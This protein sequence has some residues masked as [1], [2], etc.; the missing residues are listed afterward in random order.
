MEQ[1]FYLCFSTYADSTKPAADSSLNKQLSNE[2][3]DGWIP[4]ISLL[5]TLWFGIM[6][7]RYSVCKKTGSSRGYTLIRLH[8]GRAW[9]LIQVV[10]LPKS[11]A[12]REIA[13][14]DSGIGSMSKKK[15]VAYSMGWAPVLWRRVARELSVTAVSLSLISR[16]KELHLD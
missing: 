4:L 3:I 1:D 11:R 16:H 2:Q 12:N 15:S 8:S 13:S 10:C 7:I 14:K 9:T 6:V 5:T